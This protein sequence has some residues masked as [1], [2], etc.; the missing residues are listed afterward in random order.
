M[1]I[2]DR[3]YGSFD[4]TDSVIL[5]LL[6]TKPVL[7]LKHINQA[8][9]SQ[10]LAPWKNVSRLEHSVGVMLLLRKYGAD[11]TEQIAG[12]LHDLPHTAFSHVADFVYE[13]P[14]HEYHEQF[15]SEFIDKTEIGEILQKHV[16][17]KTVAHPEHFLLLERNLPDLCA[18]RID[19]SLRDYFIWKKDVVA[20]ELILRDL[21]VHR[22]EF[23]F[24]TVD[25][26]HVFSQNYLELD[27]TSWA[28]PREVALYIIMAQAIRHALDKGILTN[29][30]FFTDDELV[31]ELLKTKGDA[32]IQ[33]K[34]RFF[35][36]A[37]RIEPA[38][39]ED[40]HLFVKTK[41]R[42][43]DPKVLAKGKIK[44]LSELVPGFKKEL[45][46]HQEAGKQGQYIYVYEK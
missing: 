30:D 20:I 17:P 11:L 22:K 12:L 29:K 32:Y 46:A 13:N 34:L 24:R 40:H 37:F 45:K 25:A 31:Y 3:V 4:I 10:Y 8:G 7:R 41:I 21:V 43:V 26:A 19:Y 35:T 15:H 39:K 42:A 27:R 36:P 33:K 9:A 38:T 14:N 23:M 18:D 28:N 5:E 1:H 6:Y 16:I 2:H 44:R